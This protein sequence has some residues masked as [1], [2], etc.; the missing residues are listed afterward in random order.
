MVAED[1]VTEGARSSAAMVWT[2]VSQDI[3]ASAPGVTFVVQNDLA[4]FLM[5]LITCGA[6]VC[7]CTFITVSP[8]DTIWRHKALIIGLSNGLLPDIY[9]G[10]YT[11]FA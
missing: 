11:F 3:P 10:T 5:F 2:Y 6:Y 9:I 7:D 4:N 8:G 1:P